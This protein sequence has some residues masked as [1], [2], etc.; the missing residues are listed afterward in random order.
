MSVA[1]S[2]EPVAWDA[3]IGAFVVS[4]FEEAARVLREPGWSSDPRTLADRPFEVPPG[5]LLFMDPPDHTRLRRLLSPAFTPRA[6]ERLRPR[7][8]AIADAVLDG[9]FAEGPSGD[10]ADES[11]LMSEVAYLVPLAV[12]AELFDV[13]AEGARVFRDQTP[14]LVRMLEVAPTAEDV[15][16]GA[17][18]SNEVMMFLLPL[19][20][21]RREHPRGDFVSELAAIPE[22]SLEEVVATCVLLLAAGHET[23]ANLIG[24]GAFALMSDR[25]QIAALHA[26]P[27]RAVEELLRAETPV[28]LAGRAALTDHDLGGTRVPAGSRVVIRLDAVNRDPRR[29]PDPDRL[30]L[31]R[32]PV[33]HLAFG[34]GHHY[35]LGAALA[36]LETAETLTRLFARF[37]GLTPVDAEPRWR[38]SSTFHGLSELVVRPGAG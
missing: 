1:A 30:D 32:E 2:A 6:V 10:P 34:A 18:A 15:A 37:P 28:K 36:R 9:L 20:L 21:E 4:G 25:T 16:R 35:C 8:A 3:H 22:L 27:A 26:D 31:A 33:P 23:T 17:E 38:T 29:F 11:D 19:L 5:A 14:G 24:N 13:G 7:V 12:I